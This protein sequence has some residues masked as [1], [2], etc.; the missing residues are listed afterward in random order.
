[1]TDPD[2]NPENRYVNDLR[3]FGFSQEQVL[4]ARTSIVPIGLALLFLAFVGAIV[5]S[6]LI[7]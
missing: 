3:R 5:G 1:V 2:K 7:P 4:K 6:G